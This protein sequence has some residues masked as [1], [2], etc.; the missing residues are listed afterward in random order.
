LFDDSPTKGDKMRYRARQEN[1]IATDFDEDLLIYDLAH[2]KAYSLNPVAASVWRGCDPSKAVGELEGFAGASP[3]RKC[4]ESALNE[5]VEADLLESVEEDSTP[6][7]VSRR[8]ALNRREALKTMGKIGGYVTLLPAVASIVAP[9]PAMA[10]SEFVPPPS[11]GS[12]GGGGG[13]HFPTPLLGLLPFAFGGGHH[14]GAAPIVPLAAA[15][16]VETP[17]AV[18][19]PVATPV[20]AGAA[21]VQVAQAEVPETAP[22]IVPRVG[23]ASIPPVAKPIATTPPM[24]ELPQTGGSPESYLRLGLQIALVGG[25]IRGLVE[26]PPKKSSPEGTEDTEVH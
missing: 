15:A 1:L 26:S 12:S 13:S 24:K 17:A 10:A 21:P 7:A 23:G 16:P 6:P 5:L 18:L 25:L 8:E 14:H 19:A 20:I 2:H 22:V 11:G 9:T 4:L 3:D